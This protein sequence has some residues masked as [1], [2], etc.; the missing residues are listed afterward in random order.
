M[1]GYDTMTKIMP[2]NN[3][4]KASRI[5]NKNVINK[6]KNIAETVKK[7]SV[8]AKANECFLDFEENGYFISGGKIYS[9]IFPR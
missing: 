3:L 5:K 1:K 8:K 4:S 9:I 7:N 2:L 6:T